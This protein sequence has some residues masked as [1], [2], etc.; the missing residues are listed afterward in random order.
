MMEKKRSVGVKEVGV[1]VL[2]Y[3]LWLLV[4][5]WRLP[6][7]DRL[8]L[9]LLYLIAS[10]NILRLKKWARKFILYLSG[11]IVASV[12]MIV[13]TLFYRNISLISGPTELVRTTTRE[14]TRMMMWN[15]IIPLLPS[16]FFFIFFTRPKVKAL[17]SPERGEAE[18]KEAV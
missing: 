17:F 13:L 4:S 3:S 2:L 6:S 8:L 10:I 5:G 11:F 1:I 16:I 15:V 7:L 12:I 18:S 14:F 9:G